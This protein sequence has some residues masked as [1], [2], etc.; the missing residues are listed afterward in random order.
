MSGITLT[1]FYRYDD[2]L[3]DEIVFPEDTFRVDLFKSCL[4]REWGMQCPYIQSFPD[5]KEQIGSWAAEQQSNISMIWRACTESYDPIE[6]YDRYEDLEETPNVI[7]SHSGTDTR[8]DSSG[9][10][11]QLHQAPYGSTNF[12]KV[13]N[14]NN[15]T[16]HGTEGTQY[17][18]KITETGSRKHKN[19]IHGNIGVT[20][21][22]QMILAEIKGRRDLNPYK[23]LADMFADEFLSKVC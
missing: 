12:M 19:H 5:L 10:D 9:G 23:I 6:N 17:G 7:T 8:T 22:M 14:Q 21:A 13:I 4:I 1:G 3:F 15:I 2:T 16:R 11:D 18:H 20:T